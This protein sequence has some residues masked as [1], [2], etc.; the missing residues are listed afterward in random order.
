M[1]DWL[2]GVVWMDGDINTVCSV[3]QENQ[4]QTWIKMKVDGCRVPAAMTAVSNPLDVSPGVSHPKNSGEKTECQLV[5]AAEGV[6]EQVS[7]SDQ[8]PGQAG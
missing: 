6:A 7:R 1:P 2:K 5:R 4:V 3:V 8:Q